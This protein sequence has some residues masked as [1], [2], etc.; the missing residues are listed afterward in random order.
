MK[1][2]VLTKFYRGLCEMIDLVVD[3]NGQL[4]VPIADGKTPL[5]IN[6]LPAF[7]PTDDNIATLTDVNGNA[8][9]SLFNPLLESTVKGG[10]ASFN[11][12]RTSMEVKLLGVI[13]Y[14]CEALLVKLAS[15]DTE[16]NDLSLMKLSSLVS[17]Y[18]STA[19]TLIDQKT[20]ENWSHIYENIVNKYISKKHITLVVSKG[21]KLNDVKYNRIGV[22]TFPIGEE[23]FTLPSKETTV[24]DV[25]L[26]NKDVHT[27]KSL[28][29]FI[30]GDITN[31]VDGIQI[32]SLNRIAPSTHVL[33]TMYDRIYSKL[34]NIIASVLTSDI[35]DDIKEL[36]RLKPLPYNIVD[37]T[38]IIN[39]MEQEIK[40]TPSELTGSIPVSNTP[41]T[42]ARAKADTGSFWDR[43]ES[44]SREPALPPVRSYDRQPASYSRPVREPIREPAVRYDQRT[45][46]LPP[47]ENPP[48][49]NDRLPANED[50]YDRQSYNRQPSYNRPQ[51]RDYDN[52]RSSYASRA[53]PR[54]V[55]SREPTRAVSNHGSVRN[56]QTQHG[57]ARVIGA[58]W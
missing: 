10:N 27:F 20:V 41:V 21:G 3:D 58:G 5:L 39:D 22:I 50:M 35:E 30:V 53:T 29:E 33:L 49:R 56:V 31:I 47:W 16:V 1:D 13:H 32:G 17:R 6:K 37:L 34:E 15:T 2:T 26:R 14:L 23:L 45:A 28:F 7:L 48:V 12:L 44:K 38:G 43:M 4:F 9:K 40:R 8:V 51:S 54:L 36:I 25:K 57:H 18:K 42:T 46:D 24:L 19:K 11:K 52:G 55:N